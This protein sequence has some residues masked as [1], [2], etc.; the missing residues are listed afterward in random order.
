MAIGLFF[1]SMTPSV[2]LKTNSVKF[3]PVKGAALE[4]PRRRADVKARPGISD[5]LAGIRNVYP[6]NC[7]SLVEKP[8]ITRLRGP[9]DLLI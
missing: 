3:A 9:P 6:V 1:P 7:T 5:I 8:P 4:E 2:G